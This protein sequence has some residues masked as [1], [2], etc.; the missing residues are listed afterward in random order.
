MPWVNTILGKTVS[1]AEQEQIKSE[2][3]EILTDILGK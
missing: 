1:K 2:I 3:A